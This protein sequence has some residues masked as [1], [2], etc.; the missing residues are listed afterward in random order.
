MIANRR[1]FIAT[2]AALAAGVSTFSLLSSGVSWAGD[3][4]GVVE[5]PGISI[6]ELMKPGPLGDMSEGSKD[7]PV[8]IIEYSSMTCE[9]C[10][11]F[12]RNVYP[13]VKEK[14]IDTGKVRLIMREFP[15]DRL[16]L[17]AAMMVRCAD[18]SQYFPMITVLYQQQNEWSKASDPVTALFKIAKLAGFTED[19]F[20]ACLKDQ[21]IAKGIRDVMNK[22]R[23]KFAVNVTPTFFINGQKLNGGLSFEDFEKLV[24]RHLNS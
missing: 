18:E 4:N 10:A 20:N 24:L 2:T 22:G 17:A 1:R 15:L 9:H 14:Y 12:H 7:A 11:R 3:E 5:T 13:L 8:T 19:K 6:D 16:A 21:E 23:E